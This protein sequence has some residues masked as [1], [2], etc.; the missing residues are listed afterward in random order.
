M[1]SIKLLCDLFADVP[2]PD[3]AISAG[4]GRIAEHE[5]AACKGPIEKPSEWLRQ[6]NI[7]IRECER[8]EMQG[9]AALFYLLP[10][11]TDLKDCEVLIPKGS[12]P[13]S[14]DTLWCLWHEIGHAM[15]YIQVRNGQR[16]VSPNGYYSNRH[17]VALRDHQETII[18]WWPC[19]DREYKT[20]LKELWAETV[21]CAVMKP[22]QM[23]TD[24]L[25]DVRLA[26]EERN[27]P[28]GFGKQPSL[29]LDAA[30]LNAALQF[31]KGFIGKRQKQIVMDCIHGEEGA[32]FAEKMVQLHRQ[33]E[34]MP[35]TG[36]TD[37]DDAMKAIVHLHYFIGSCDWYIIEKDSYSLQHQAFG[38]ANLG[39]D[40]Y[41]EL[42]YISLVEITELHAELDFHWTPKPLGEVLGRTPKP[43]PAEV[44]SW[45][46]EMLCD[47][48]WCDNA[49]RFATEQEAK[50]SGRELMS[51][52]MTPRDCRATLTSDPVN[53]VF[54]DG[55]NQDL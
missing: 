43:A 30:P 54:K 51:R 39:N 53:R 49:L 4:G 24:L 10:G 5:V 2:G 18:E 21:A 32:F 12:S 45:K 6:Y 8:S 11:S 25:N 48:K 19:K 22:W 52:W 9:S 1:D 3:D 34:A 36:E 31:L 55:R 33:I 29:E 27:V 16:V 46:P 37:N 41:A 14:A 23:P 38:W 47:G 26:L 35:K 13:D 15:D 7:Q 40:A 17:H 28:I 42:G 50:D 44:K 20:Q